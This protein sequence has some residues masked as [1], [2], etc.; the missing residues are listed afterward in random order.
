[1]WWLC[2]GI[3][4]LKPVHHRPAVRALARMAPLGSRSGIG[5][6]GLDNGMQPLPTAFL[7]P[8]W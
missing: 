1:M 8:Q 3:V 7:V 2:R 5:V 4:V 6:S